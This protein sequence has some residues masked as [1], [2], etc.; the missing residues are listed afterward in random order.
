[1]KR[2]I[3]SVALATMALASVPAAAASERHHIEREYRKDMREAQRD[4]WK[5]RRRAEREY[6]EDRRDLRRDRRSWSD[7]RRWHR[8]DDRR[9]RSHYRRGW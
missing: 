6:R 8:N 5:D 2:L 3:I 7:G 9:W 1:M 4:Y